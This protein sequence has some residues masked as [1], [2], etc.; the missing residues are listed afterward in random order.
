MKLYTYSK[1]SLL[2]VLSIVSAV[3]FTSCQKEVPP[4]FKKI[5]WKPGKPVVFVA[6]NES[7]GI[8]DV[9]KYWI[10]G[11]EVI[12]SDGTKYATA[13][14]I[15]VTGND[16]YVSGRDGGPAYWK[17][18][19]EISLPVKFITVKEYYAAKSI[20]VSGNKV[21]AAGNDSTRAVY[22]KDGAEIML[23]LTDAKGHYDY[24]YANSIFI[25]GNDIYVAGYHGPNAV[26]WKNGVEV[27]LT[28][29]TTDLYGSEIA[30]SIY[31]SGGNVYVVG[32]GIY[33]GA[34]FSVPRYWKNGINESASLNHAN[35]EYYGTNSVFVTGNNVYIAGIASHKDI[36]YLFL[37]VYWNNGNVT[38]LSGD[39]SEARSIYVKGNDVYTSGYVFESGSYYAVYW[40]NGTEVKLTDGTYTAAANSIFVK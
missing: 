14:S 38:V 20:Y 40:K 16:V 15:F 6:G 21:Y 28:G 3:V 23:N 4:I 37:G 32:A 9:A 12:L 18:N 17:N 35:F 36:P 27:Y 10:N 24:S 2:I 5:D 1:K 26:Y 34:G 31:V 25:S 19:T 30:N 7:N 33:T 13:N 8:T 11:Q 22:W 29:N 39:D